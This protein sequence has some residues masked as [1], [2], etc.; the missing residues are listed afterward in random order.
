LW[1][2]GSDRLPQVYLGTSVTFLWQIVRPFLAFA[3]TGFVVLLPFL[4]GLS[5][6][7]RT[8]APEPKTIAALPLPLKLLLFAGLFLFPVAIL[9][10][11]VAKDIALFRPDYLA[12]P[13]VKAFRPYLVTVVLLTALCVLLSV[14]RQVDYETGVL[15]NALQL[16]LNLA[17]QA[18]AIITMRSVGL[19]Y[20]H[21]GCYFPW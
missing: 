5:I 3:V 1:Y 10:T 6:Y 15:S 2:C 13:I 7:Y 8:G 12:R 11:T 16:L 9:T 4:V 20:R 17:V 19:F 18:G 21:Y 14:T